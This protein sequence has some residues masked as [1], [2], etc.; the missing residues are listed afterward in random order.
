MRDDFD[1]KLL[2][3]AHDLFQPLLAFRQC[4]VIFEKGTT[5]LCLPGKVVAGFNEPREL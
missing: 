1:C 3:H 2:T 5:E 4:L